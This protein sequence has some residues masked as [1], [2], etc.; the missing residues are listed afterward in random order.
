V[1]ARLKKN[2]SQQLIESS[3]GIKVLHQDILHDDKVFPY[4]NS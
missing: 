2:I 1:A 3:N 4:S